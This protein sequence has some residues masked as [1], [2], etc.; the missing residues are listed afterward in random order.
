MEGGSHQLGE[1]SP[2]S[3][4]AE[5]AVLLIAHLDVGQFARKTRGPAVEAAAEDQAGTDPVAE[6]DVDQAVQPAAGAE[7]ELPE[8]SEVGVVLGHHRDVEIPP[9]GFEV[10]VCGARPGDRDHHPRQ[11]LGGDAGVAQRS[12]QELCPQPE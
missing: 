7:G 3:A 9:Q 11:P 8:S 6:H 5:G 4:D 12:Q 2:T 10:D 1:A